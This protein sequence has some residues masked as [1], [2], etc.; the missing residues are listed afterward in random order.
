MATNELRVSQRNH[1]MKNPNRFRLVESKFR[2][3]RK[4]RNKGYYATTLAQ[5]RIKFVGLLTS[6]NDITNVSAHKNDY[7]ATGLSS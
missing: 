2:K 7:P 6:E 1:H 4:R 5:N 3:G